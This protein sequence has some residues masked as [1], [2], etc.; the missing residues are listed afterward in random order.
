MRPP[1]KN[2]GGN[3]M[4]NLQIG[5][6]RF[7]P[8]LAAHYGEKALT[9]AI[10]L[11]V[12]W[13]AAKVAKW[14]FAKA[15]DKIEFLQRDTGSGESVGASLGKIVKLLIWLFGLTAILTALNLGSVTRPVEELLTSI[16]HFVPNLIGAGI[17]FFIG[18]MIARIVRDLVSTALSTVNFD[19]WVNKSGA[20]EVTGN[21]ALS[22]TL[23]TVVYALIMLV[24]AIAALQALKI[25]SIS[26]PLVGMLQTFLLA[27]PNIVGAAV[28]LGLGYIIGKWVAGLVEEILPGLGV[29][30]SVSALG[31]L[32]AGVT[33][34]GV[35]A[36]IAMIAI[37]LVSAI[38]ATRLLAFPELT[39]LVTQIVEIGGSVIFGGVIIAVGFM[40]A[41]ML[42]TLFSAG[43]TTAASLIKYATMF[44]FAFIGLR[45]MNI[46][47]EIVEMAFGALVI[48]GAA[49][50]A[51][52]F[53]LGGKDAAA[54]KLAEMEGG[55]KPAAPAKKPA[56]KKAADPAE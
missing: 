16:V 29:N 23:A 33:A 20:E 15:V 7:D 48:G 44:L 17:I 12:T 53:G 43:N 46:G 14:A 39:A 10:I 28:L 52:A 50:A 55:A 11:I 34:S 37:L 41:N 9:V 19:K 25:S 45:E 54:R 13:L 36:K 3:A 32:P 27:I 1:V 18:S 26:D 51:L 24:T 31:I 38:A 5:G 22:S 49:A 42:A 56:A 30:R 6:Y 21:S 47:N 40:L 4:E 2:I 35:V 8:E